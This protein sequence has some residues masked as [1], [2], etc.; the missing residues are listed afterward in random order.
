MELCQLPAYRHCLPS[1]VSP[2]LDQEQ[3]LRDSIGTDAT[4]TVG[5][6][7]LPPNSSS[8]VR[9][10]LVKTRAYVHPFQNEVLEIDL[11]VLLALSNR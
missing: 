3:L 9:L 11:A 1:S 5:D 2:C 4:V 8:T 10:S 7:K 6:C